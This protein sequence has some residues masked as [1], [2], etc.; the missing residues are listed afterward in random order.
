MTTYGP[1]KFNDPEIQNNGNLTLRDFLS[2][3]RRSKRLLIL[4]VCLCGASSA[5][6]SALIPPKQEY[7]VTIQI[8]RALEYAPSGP[9]KGIEGQSRLLEL[10]TELVTRINLTLNQSLTDPDGKTKQ[11]AGIFAK[12]IKGTDIVQMAVSSYSREASR[13]VADEIVA[14]ILRKHEEA[15]IIIHKGN[16][17]IV[18]SG[19]KLRQKSQKLPDLT[20][21][22][23]PSGIQHVPDVGRRLFFSLQDLNFRPT[24]VIG[25][26]FSGPERRSELNVAIYGLMGSTTGFLFGSLVLL[27][28]LA[29]RRD[30]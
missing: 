23:T 25:A 26:A 5:T 29:S 6:L 10:P 7:V 4:L 2:E 18:E 15:K 11:N 22:G 19:E 12:E 27:I 13:R 14:N 21:P 20:R 16:S 3:I 9:M 30:R 28:S 24:Q 17:L 8:G 1:D